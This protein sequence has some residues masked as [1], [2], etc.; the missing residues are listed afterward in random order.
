MLNFRTLFLDNFRWIFPEFR[1][2]ENVRYPHVDIVPCFHF[3]SVMDSLPG[4]IVVYLTTDIH[5]QRYH[6]YFIR[7]LG[8]GH[9]RHFTNRLNIENRLRNGKSSL[10]Q[11]AGRTQRDRIDNTCEITS[12]MESRFVIT[13]PIVGYIACTIAK[14]QRFCPIHRQSGGSYI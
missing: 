9:S 6:E 3:V 10:P 5:R 4:T 8:Q 2:G 14:L 12:A 1:A 13:V 11:S 7:I